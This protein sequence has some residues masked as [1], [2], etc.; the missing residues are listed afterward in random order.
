VVP[1]FQNRKVRPREINQ[2]GPAS[3]GS[4]VIKLG[5]EHKSIKLQCVGINFWSLCSRERAVIK[6]KF[7]LYSSWKMLHSL[8]C[9]EQPSVL[10]ILFENSILSFHVFYTCLLAE[11][12]MA[13]MILPW[14][15]IDY[16]SQETLAHLS[17]NWIYWKPYWLYLKIG[18]HKC[19]LE[20]F[21]KFICFFMMS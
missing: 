2:L 10:R 8:L 1:I 12:P 6:H 17:S 5:Y 7:L 3:H 15:T 13:H 11:C 16:L 20:I 4:W 18:C 14:K 19:T 21:W 9:E